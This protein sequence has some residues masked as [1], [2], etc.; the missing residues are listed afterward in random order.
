MDPALPR[1][2]PAPPPPPLAH[3]GGA[4]DATPRPTV[5][6]PP[7]PPPPPAASPRLAVPPAPPARPATAPSGRGRVVPVLSVVLALGAGALGGALVQQERTT[8]TGATATAMPASLA[9][10]GEALDVAGVV[11]ALA[12]SVV[13]IETTVVSRR[14]PMQ[15]EGSGAGTGVVLDADGL[16]LTNAHVV[17]GATE[18]WVTVAGD[19][20]PR[21]ATLVAGDTE[22]DIAVL[23]L[24][25]TSGLV[26]ASL[27]DADQIAVGDGVVAIGN[28][29]ALEGGM[30]VTQGIVSALDRSIAT[31]SGTLTDLIQTDAA[32]SSGNSGGPLV[33]ARGEVVGINTAVASSSGSVQA[34]N[35]GF[36]ISIDR[37]LDVVDDLLD[38]VA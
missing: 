5:P 29:L 14:G 38:R 37:A 28:A 11:D 30:S 22:A 4:A 34:S 27:A 10:E 25:D 16:V 21:A 18:I 35:I 2:L 20:E 23:Q 17:D 36:A 15:V 8:S 12:D 13:S 1:R 26:A 9:L 31:S 7:P 6:A 3:W 24:R 33:N 19:G 32:I